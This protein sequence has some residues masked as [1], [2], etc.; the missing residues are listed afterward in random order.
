VAYGA[1]HPW[2]YQP[3][4]ST[5]TWLLNTSLKKTF[6][7]TERVGL[8]LQVDAFNVFNMP[9]NSPSANSLGLSYTNTNLN[10]PRQ[11][12]LTGRLNW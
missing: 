1:L 3:I 5:N 11:L 8:R 4:A 9:G 2:I 10:T 12:Q 7:L 6:R